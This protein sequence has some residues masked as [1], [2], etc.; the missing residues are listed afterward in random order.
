[1]KCR[2]PYMEALFWGNVASVDLLGNS[3]QYVAKLTYCIVFVAIPVKSLAPGQVTSPPGDVI[4]NS[5][6]IGQEQRHVISAWGSMVT[7]R[8]NEANETRDFG[9]IVILGSLAFPRHGH[10]KGWRVHISRT[11]IPVDFQ[12]WRAETR[13]SFDFL[14]LIGHT[15]PQFVDEM[16]T[17]V[18]TL[19]KMGV[20]AMP[21][22]RTDFIG[23]GLESASPISFRWGGLG[24]K[25]LSLDFITKSVLLFDL[26]FFFIHWGH[27]LVVLICR[28]V[29]L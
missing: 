5:D 25:I 22:R 12:I 15:G 3:K 18:L 4:N 27:F 26:S 13:D 19:E 9:H 8:Q 21:F 16:G 7:A 1:M 2:L 17:S 29:F 11:D 23:I 6:L 14:K 24:N 20:K 10:V 28:N